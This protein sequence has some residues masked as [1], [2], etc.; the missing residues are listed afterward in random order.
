L[1]AALLVAAAALLMRVGEGDPKPKSVRDRVP[2][3]RRATHQDRERMTSRQ[4]LDQMLPPR[5]AEGETQRP[6][7]PR[8]PVL[9]AL[10]GP[11]KKG[12]VVF[13]ANAVRNSPIGQLLVDCI[14]SEDDGEG[15]ARLR[16]RSGIDPLTDLD[17]IAVTDDMVVFSGNFKGLKPEVFQGPGTQFGD[18]A[19]LDR[20]L[21]ADGGAGRHLGT[22][23][24]QMIAISRDPEL[25]KQTFERIEGKRP[26]E[27]GGLTDEQAYGE[28]YG[29]ISPDQFAEM[30][31][32]A[33]PELAD[34]VGQVAQRIELHVDT[35]G[36]IG[37]AARIE[38]G[39][40]TDSKEMTRA[41]GAAMSVAR[42]K[43]RADGRDDIAE[44]L[45]M[46]KVVADGSNFRLEAGVPQ[47]WV[48]T[49]LK[50]CIERNQAR[51]A[52]E[53]QQAEQAAQPA[54][55]DPPN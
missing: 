35:S 45:D 50:K 38:A 33:N 21:R 5:P 41:L 30:V 49:A 3:P 13:E 2:I 26:M 55:P 48:E 46:G 42:L 39:N 15:L 24:D 31:A 16:E 10:G 12:A 8:D 32:E 53:A 17:R 14:N 47:A 36:D 22:W 51:R 40:A 1:G 28:V 6:A 27:S 34:R 44:L 7:R 9:A 25:L 19:N 54:P 4:T 43:A 37:V 52:E 18:S 20:M 23:G 11:F 29:V